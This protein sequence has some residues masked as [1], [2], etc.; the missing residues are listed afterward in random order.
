MKGQSEDLTETNTPG[1]GLSVQAEKR[2]VTIYTDGACSGNPGR[3]GYGVVMLTAE[4]R[5]ELSAGYRRTTNN[6]M[7]LLAAITGLETLRFPCRVTLFTDSEYM[8]NGITKGWAAKWRKN[9]WRKADKSP[10]ANPDLWER[11]LNLCETHEVTYS[12]V[13]GHT[14]D[15]ENERCDELSVAAAKAAELLVDG[16]YE[17]QNAGKK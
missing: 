12:W 14:G 1:N 2:K 7:E 10:V 3:G 16:E 5:R 8:A 13:R 11:L 4:K 15:T 9:G 6:R 17:R